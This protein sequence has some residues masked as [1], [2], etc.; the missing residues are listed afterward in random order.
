MVF[1]KLTK[2]EY[3]V[4]P[5]NSVPSTTTITDSDQES[6]T[7]AICLENMSETNNICQLPNCSHLF[8]EEC[9]IKWLERQ[10]DSCPLC[11]E[12]VNEQTEQIY[13]ENLLQLS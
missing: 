9:V 8:H 2:K 1:V 12:H 5:C 13:G 6:E 10:H 7:C 3:F 4:L 11:R